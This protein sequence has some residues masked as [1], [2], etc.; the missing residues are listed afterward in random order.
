MGNIKSNITETVGKTPLVR[1]NKLGSNSNA[2][3][4][5]KL[6][7]FN[8]CGS[9]KDRIAVSMIQEAEK[10][11]RINSETVIVEPTSGNTGIG[12]AFVCAQR[13]YRLIVC[14]PDSSSIEKRKLLKLFGTE[15]V[16]TPESEGML[17]AVQKSE[18]IVRNTQNSF[19]PQQFKNPAN[20]KIH[21]DTTG[22]E[23]WDDTDGKVDIIIG[24]VGTGGSIT[25]I[26]EFLK[27]KKK[28][29]IAV[30]VEPKESP[31]LSGGKP[32]PHKIQ[33]IGTGFIPDVLMVDLIDEIITVTSEAAGEMVRYLARKEGILC[34]ISSGAAV[35]AAKEI[36]NRKENEDKVIVVILPDTGERYIST[37]LF[38][39]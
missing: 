16:L 13:G 27:K 22:Q 10:E 7:S 6:E 2:T 9:L 32:G 29:L 36:A 21:R 1:L 38:E 11:G 39:E 28:G 37:W 14:M 8:P 19:M 4:L 25:G 12:L 24:G 31:V 18:N 23:I 17:G 33:G 35:W 3:V 20:P 5:A 26:V 30:A 34:G 15:L